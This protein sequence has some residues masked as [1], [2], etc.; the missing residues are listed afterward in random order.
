MQTWGEHENSAQKGTD[1]C[2]T[3]AKLCLSPFKPKFERQ[4][5]T[6]VLNNKKLDYTGL[7][8]NG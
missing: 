7:N 1:H 2:I 8:I 4:R 6:K 5:L 3:M